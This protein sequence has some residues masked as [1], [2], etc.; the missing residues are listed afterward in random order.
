MAKSRLYVLVL[1][2]A[3]VVPLVGCGGETPHRSQSRTSAAAGFSAGR[4]VTGESERAVKADGYRHRENRHREGD[5]DEDRP[6]NRPDPDDSRV[7]NFGQRATASQTRAV[8]M[9]VKHYYTAALRRDANVGCRLISRRLRTNPH[10]GVIAE[11]M[12]PPPLSLPALSGASCQRIVSV[13]FKEA[14]SHIAAEAGTVRVIL[15]RVSGRLGLALLGFSAAPERLLR[16]EREGGRW[17]LAELLDS[18]V[19]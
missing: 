15:V 16:L 11:E 17:H 18:E 9:L 6:L 12:Y 4:V 13:L 7:R 14:H 10:L 3:S 5:E 2:L 19:P 8:E 1:F